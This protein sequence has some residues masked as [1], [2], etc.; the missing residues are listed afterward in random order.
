MQCLCVK[1][2]VIQLCTTLQPHGRYSPWNSPGQTT[3]V[4][5][6]C[7]L[8]GIF[9]TQGSNPGPPHC[10][11]ILY[12]LSHREAKEYWSGEPNPSP[13]DLPDPEIQ[14]GSPALQ[15]DSLPTDQLGKPYIIT[16]LLRVLPI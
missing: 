12:Q 2:K 16:V 7:L 13:L 14:P 15:L 11:Q 4:D 6:L 5:S 3:G 10:S 9:R 8:Q 1:V